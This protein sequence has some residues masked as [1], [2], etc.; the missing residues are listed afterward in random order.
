MKKYEELLMDD[1]KERLTRERKCYHIEGRL[2]S[3]KI[4]KEEYVTIDYDGLF[5]QYIRDNLRYSFQVDIQLKEMV[6]TII[7]NDEAEIEKKKRIKQINIM[8]TY[9]QNF[10]ERPMNWNKAM[11]KLMNGDYKIVG[12]SII[13][14]QNESITLFF[15]SDMMVT[16]S[17]GSDLYKR[18]TPDDI[19]LLVDKILSKRQFS[20]IIYNEVP[21]LCS[22]LFHD[23]DKTMYVKP[24]GERFSIRA[25]G[26][27]YPEISEG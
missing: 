15:R 9:T 19:G 5:K 7:N 4:D 22:V 2:V 10:M 11:K 16:V 14:K 8:D 1:A 25:D 18:P 20:T 27:F 24:N 26:H 13:V 3:L 21:I 12:D 23:E 6:C 17:S